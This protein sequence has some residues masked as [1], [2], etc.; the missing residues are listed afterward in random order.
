MLT[1]P[2]QPAVVGLDFIRFFAALSVVW[3]HLGYHWW[4]EKGSA[5][6]ILAGFPPFD[7]LGATFHWGWV[8][9]EIF[10][11]LSGYVIAFSAEGKT[12]RDFVLSRFWRLFPALWVCAPLSLLAVLLLTQSGASPFSPDDLPGTFARTMVLWPVGPWMDGAYWTL[13]IE[14][15]FYALVFC[16]ILLRKFDRLPWLLWTIGFV[17]IIAMPLRGMVPTRL[18][19]LLLLKH[20]CFFAIGGMFYLASK[21]KLPRWQWGL[22]LLFVAVGCVK[23]QRRAIG[24]EQTGIVPI[25]VWLIAIALI[26]VAARYNE[27]WLRRLPAGSAGVAR[28]MGLATYPLYLIHNVIGLAIMRWLMAT[29]ATPLL[30][31]VTGV[32]AVIALSFVIAL[33][34]EP[35]LKKLLRASTIPAIRTAG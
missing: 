34:A 5:D 16:L 33:V 11:V 2:K 1:S 6:Q 14:I 3:Y 10:F 22:V 24:S 19:E 30:A 28:Q 4:A 23:I 7:F 13:G 17:S 15:S 32:A 26:A 29:G 9:V 27:A 25:I 20:G 8:G 12:A 21:Q 31:F 18:G 35:W